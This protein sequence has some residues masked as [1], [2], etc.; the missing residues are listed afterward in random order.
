MCRRYIGR[1][2][3]AKGGAFAS[4]MGATPQEVANNEFMIDRA[5][6]LRNKL[7]P[8][9]YATFFPSFGGTIEQ[10]A[11]KD[12]AEF[13]AAAAGKFKEGIPADNEAFE[14]YLGGSK[15][16]AGDHV[17]VCDFHMYELL[18]QQ[19]SMFGL[20]IYTGYSKIQAFMAAFG[21][22]P[23]IQAAYAKYDLPANNEMAWTT[24]ANIV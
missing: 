23:Q 2:A 9:G 20:G 16:F 5:M 11:G 7:V 17:T 19:R 21:G 6:E 1:K 24:V 18:D 3:V 8:I 4:I 10:V 13:Y 22:L 14:K 15:Y 12:A